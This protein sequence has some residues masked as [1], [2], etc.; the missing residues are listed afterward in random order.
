[1][2][3]ALASGTPMPTHR[4]KKTRETIARIRGWLVID[5]YDELERICIEA[6]ELSPNGH[7]FDVNVSAGQW[8]SLRCM[9]RMSYC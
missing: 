1:M 2:L 4:Y 3:N 5:F 8:H 6:I 7:V 9:E